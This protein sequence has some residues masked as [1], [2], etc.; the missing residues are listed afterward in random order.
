MPLQ[1]LREFLRKLIVSMD[2]AVLAARNVLAGNVQSPAIEHAAATRRRSTAFP[3]FEARRLERRRV[4]AVDAT[5]QAGLLHIN[6]SN[7][8]MQDA[9]LLADGSNFFVDT[10]ANA[11]L[12]G[13]ELSGAIGDLQSV[14]VQGPG[15]QG[16]F[17]WG[18]DFRNA[19]LIPNG[20][21]VDVSGVSGIHIA[22][23]WTAGRVQLAASDS[24]LFDSSIHVE[25]DLSVLTDQHG[26][27]DDTA[28]AKVTVDQDFFASAGG[29]IAL[30][31]SA[32]NAWLVNGS[33]TLYSDSSVQLGNG[34]D[35]DSASLSIKAM[36][37]NV[38]ETNDVILFDHEIRGPYSLT[39]GGNVVFDG[40][41]LFSSKVE[42]DSSGSITD[43][44]GA[45]VLIFGNLSLQSDQFITL[46]DSNI[47]AWAVTGTTKATAIGD[48]RLGDAGVWDSPRLE[49]VAANAWVTDI[50]SVA[51]GNT[52]IA[53]NYSLVSGGS[54]VID[55]N[56]SVSGNWFLDATANSGSIS[57]STNVDVQVGGDLFFLAKGSVTLADT[58]PSSWV[59][60]GQASVWTD[61]SVQ[62][63]S[64]GVWDSELLSVKSFNADIRERNEV[65]LFDHEIRGTYNLVAGGDVH[66]S[67]F[68]LFSSNVNI[69][70]QGAIDDLLGTE[71]LSFGAFL[72][73]ATG[74]IRL[75]DS[76]SDAWFISGT[77][78]L[79]TPGVVELG[80]GGS[81][82]SSRL[83]ITAAS[84]AVSDINSVTVGNS[85]LAGNYSLSAAG[86]ATVD[87]TVNVNGNWNINANSI[88]DSNNARV[89]VVGNAI[90]Q[91]TNAITLADTANASWVIG[92]TANLTT[93]SSVSLGQGG[94]W[95]SN[96]LEITAASATVTDIN[97][98]TIG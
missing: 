36:S 51:I 89:N 67:S 70:S 16:N 73:T 25:K 90:L 30:S 84:A 46:S 33:A 65:T 7:G 18:G 49:I 86:A 91:S 77:A 79:N 61:G 54:A 44:S 59:T 57:D 48:V 76:G 35:W 10:N 40:F 82:D 37:A 98:V 97:G 34:G 95:D 12:D 72:V 50:R 2:A 3:R 47:D 8:G 5:F 14:L 45:D 81:W 69:Q 21:A 11:S 78:R 64:Q 92:G 56:V 39:T 66:F 17:F 83:E 74:P 62:L 41:S 43:L 15:Q 55:G 68:N 26:T 53:G 31:D 24:V 13:M 63:G 80:Q 29:S 23:Q 9:S 38:H 22:S 32:T 87:G 4:F 1:T 6:I 19:P 71:I 85:Q 42:V 28:N 20:L 52:N 96:R 94:S 58:N 88:T 27:I 60:Q 93:P 75:A